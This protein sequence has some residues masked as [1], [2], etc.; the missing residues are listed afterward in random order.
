MEQDKVN[1]LSE[2]G[3]KVWDEDD[4][5][6]RTTAQKKRK[7]SFG[8]WWA[9][10]RPTKTAVFWGW[11]ASIILTIFIGFTWG[12]WVTGASA[13]R[14]AKTMASD[15]VLQ[16]LA[17]LCVAQFNQDP[18]NEQKLKELKE[19][20]SYQRGNYVEKQGWATIAGEEKPDRQVANECVKLLM[21]VG[22]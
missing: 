14:M 21:L 4:D 3:K 19:L 17:P 8:E 9:K 2:V 20:S 5:G 18:A 1:R 6:K 10:T 11:L 7:V 22:Q 13:Q 15:A 16:R 12:G